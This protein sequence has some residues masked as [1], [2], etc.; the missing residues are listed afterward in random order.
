MPE[1]PDLTVFA[2]NLE[3]LVQA[4][5]ITVVSYQGKE[6][7]ILEKE[8]AAGLIAAQI[9]GVAR[10]GKQICFSLNNGNRLYVHLMLTGGFVVSARP[11]PAEFAMLTIQFDDDSQMAVTD[12]KGWA[13]VALNAGNSSAV[14]ALE[15][16]VDHL[17]AL[18][19][20][21][22][23]TLVK[24]L[25]VDQNL[26]GGIGNA[27]ADEILWE[28]RISP[29]SAVGRIPPE[30]ISVLAESI[31]AV[32]EKAIACLRERHPGIISG[33]FREFLAVHNPSCK[34]SPGGSRIIKEQV[35]GKT[36]YYT[37]E[38]RLY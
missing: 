23:K 15:V 8:L 25:L 24:A 18:F 29:K 17:V 35:G 38:Q 5:K 32:L 21:K 20:K 22:P 19:A 36:T 1:L 30:V 11:A 4:K 33:E 37:D 28:A 26:I 31:P 16:T 3:R 6:R 9:K 10:A 13:K 34:I 2:E 27:Y 14:D 7:T 12:P